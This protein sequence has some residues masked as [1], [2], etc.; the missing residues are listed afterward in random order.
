MLFTNL[1]IHVVFYRNGIKLKPVKRLQKSPPIPKS[2]PKKL[3]QVHKQKDLESSSIRNDMSKVWDSVVFGR[4]AIK[5]KRLS[6]R[7]SKRGV[8]R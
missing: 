4:S 3:H 2:P 1:V 8:K 6:K 7:S 5:S